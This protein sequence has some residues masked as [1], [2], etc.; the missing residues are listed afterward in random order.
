MSDIFIGGESPDSGLSNAKRISSGGWKIKKIHR[1]QMTDRARR[2]LTW[3]DRTG[4]LAE[5]FGFYT[6]FSIYAKWCVPLT[7]FL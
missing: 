3:P 5:K 7:E 2:C 4:Q 1:K 6:L